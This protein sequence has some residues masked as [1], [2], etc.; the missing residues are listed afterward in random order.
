VIATLLFQ[1]LAVL[2]VTRRWQCHSGSC[3]KWQ[4]ENNGPS[5]RLS[6][7]L[8]P[9]V[10]TEK[11]ALTLLHMAPSQ[12]PDM[13]LLEVNFDPQLVNLLR[14]TKYFISLGVEVPAEA[15]NV[16]ERS[17]TFRRHIG[18]LDLIVAVWNR[19]QKTILPV[20][21]PLVKQ[22]IDELHARLDDGLNNL[23]WNSSTIDKYIDEVKV[24]TK[25]HCTLILSKGG[26]VKIV[27]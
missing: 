25:P 19:I 15:R 27:C 7:G 21:L 12:K 13:H 1:A 22:Q 8:S 10:S 16:F 17:K 24:R 3:Q 18:S 14:E 2:T 5:K 23:D 26:F 4:P 9:Q 6:K 11:L 20:E